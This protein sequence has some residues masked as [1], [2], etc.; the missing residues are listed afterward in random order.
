M[1]SRKTVHRMIVHRKKQLFE[2]IMFKYAAI[3]IVASVFFCTNI[4]ATPLW[5]CTAFNDR[6]ASWNEYGKTQINTKRRAET[7]CELFN[8]KK[9]CRITCFPPRMY[10]RCLSHDTIPPI[11]VPADTQEN[12]G[13]LA[14]PGTWYWTSF[15]KQIAINGAH[16][17][18]RHN[19]QYGGCYVDPN[20]CASS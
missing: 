20:S 14:K 16:D 18:C 8:L 17:A 1:L 10:W 4:F 12:T 3:F 11:S 5:H 6:G 9:Y 19:S 13:L 2:K 7:R 15:S